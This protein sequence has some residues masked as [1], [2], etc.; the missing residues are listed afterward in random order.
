MITIENVKS[1]IKKYYSHYILPMN[2]KMSFLEPV[3]YKVVDNIEHKY[4]SIIEMIENEDESIDI[5]SLYIEYK[6]KIENYG[7]IEMF[8]LKF[9]E[10]DIDRL[11]EC[12]KN[13]EVTM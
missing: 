8:G 11:Y 3:V 10:Q 13:E 1:G 9:N 12:I 7:S 4:K 5:D 2:W 6:R